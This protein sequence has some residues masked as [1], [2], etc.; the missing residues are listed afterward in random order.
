MQYMCVCVGSVR[1]VAYRSYLT[2]DNGTCRE[3]LSV[4]KRKKGKKGL[5]IEISRR[6]I[7]KKSKRPDDNDVYI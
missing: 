1:L 5:A 6:K 4:G 7:Q 3:P 2:T